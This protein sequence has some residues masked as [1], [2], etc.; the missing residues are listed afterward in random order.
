MRGLSGG[1]WLIALDPKKLGA[2][3]PAPPASAISMSFKSGGAIDDPE[4]KVAHKAQ[5][6]KI[7]GKDAIEGVEPEA[8]RR[9]V[10]AALTLVGRKGAKSAGIKAEA[11]LADNRLGERGDVA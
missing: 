5:R 7:V 4:P 8:A 2:P 9:D 10:E 3:P 11:H 6:R 1:D